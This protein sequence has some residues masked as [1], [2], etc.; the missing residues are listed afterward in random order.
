MTDNFNRSD[1]FTPINDTIILLP[2][3]SR[4][5][6]TVTDD[7]E[8]TFYR[9]VQLTLDI[10]AVPGVETLTLD[11]EGLDSISGAKYQI[12]QSAAFSAIGVEVITVYPGIE[13]IANVQESVILPVNWRAIVTPSA[14]G[15]FTYS[16]AANLTV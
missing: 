5:V 11:I 4:T 7:Q 13:V 14:A 6:L 3:A 16:L 9:G 8:N 2:S 12:L 15:S 1:L 10:T